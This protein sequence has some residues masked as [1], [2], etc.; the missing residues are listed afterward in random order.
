MTP[1]SEYKDALE[2]LGELAAETSLSSHY[3]RLETLTSARD[4]VNQLLA[5]S[6]TVRQF[7]ALTK[8]INS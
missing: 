5:F 7:S 1:S 6:P 2:S 3:H 4:L 8:Q